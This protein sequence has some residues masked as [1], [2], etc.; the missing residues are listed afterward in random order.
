MT[1][2]LCGHPVRGNLGDN[3]CPGRRIFCGEPGGDCEKLEFRTRTRGDDTAAMITERTVAAR[4]RGRPLICGLAF[5]RHGGPSLCENHSS[6]SDR[7][8]SRFIR[9]VDHRR[10]ADISAEKSPKKDRLRTA[11]E[12]IYPPCRYRGALTFELIWVA[13]GSLETVVR[14]V[15]RKM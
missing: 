13:T 15:R 12:T 9:S 4:G 3:A 2:A 11:R 14:S 6:L 8:A 5:A 1:A 7:I 10:V